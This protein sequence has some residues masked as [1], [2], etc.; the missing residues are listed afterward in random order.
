MLLGPSNA[1]SC[2]SD[3]LNGGWGA[4]WMHKAAQEGHRGGCVR[5]ACFVW[6]AMGHLDRLC[7][8]V[9]TGTSSREQKTT[10]HRLHVECDKVNGNL[11]KQLT[12]N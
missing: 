12:F 8:I 6:V 11:A 2:F 3:A 5:A 4:F 10:A 7:I 9:C 1:K